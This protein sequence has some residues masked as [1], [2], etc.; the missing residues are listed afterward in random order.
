MEI[1]SFLLAIKQIVSPIYGN[2]SNKVRGHHF[3]FLLH[4]CIHADIPFP[5]TA[6]QSFQY[7]KPQSISFFPKIMYNL[8]MEES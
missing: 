1:K 5:S 6:G 8:N 2:S 3:I 4:F 7:E